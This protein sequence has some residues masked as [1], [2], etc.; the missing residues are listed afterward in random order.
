MEYL[1]QSNAIVHYWWWFIV[2]RRRYAKLKPA[3]CWSANEKIIYK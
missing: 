2:V 1:V 3:N